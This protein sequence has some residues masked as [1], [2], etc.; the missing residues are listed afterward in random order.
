METVEKQPAPSWAHRMRAFTD[1]LVFD[2]GGGSKPIPFSWVINFQKGGTFIFLGFLIGYYGNTSATAMVYLA[3]HGSYG[4][5][6]L[7][8]H[9]AFRDPNWERH[10]TLAGGLMGFVG[11]LGP[12][13][14]IGWLLISGT[15]QPDY[16]L[17]TNLWLCLA[18]TLHTLGVVIMVA[19]D[20]QKYYTLKYR[21]G[22]IDEGMFALVRHPNYLGEM[23][24][25]GSYALLVWH[26]LPWVILGYVWCG[27]FAVNMLMKEESLSRYPEWKDYKARTGMLLPPIS[28]LFG[29]T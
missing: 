2:L 28:R 21:K 24:L 23:M 14:L 9:F 11:V 25:Y 27:L 13:W 10:C 15:V 19:A 5:V 29:K 17:A 6:W 8:K 12:Y 18:V 20:C 7:L 1:H 16:P 26:W 22:F 4:L 3:L